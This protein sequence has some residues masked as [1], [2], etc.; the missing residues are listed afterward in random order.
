MLYLGRGSSVTQCPLCE[1]FDLRCGCGRGSPRSPGSVSRAGGVKIID[2]FAAAELPVIQSCR[3]QTV[4]CIVEYWIN[5]GVNELD[6]GE[7]GRAGRSH[8]S[9]ARWCA[10]P[11]SGDARPCCGGSDA[12]AAGARTRRAVLDSCLFGSRYERRL[13]SR[14]AQSRCRLREA[15]FRAQYLAARAGEDLGPGQGTLYS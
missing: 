9:A 8:T 10:R 13:P 11:A 3:A 5:R 1:A 7:G 2:M 14:R 15:A 4:E 6:M 12:A